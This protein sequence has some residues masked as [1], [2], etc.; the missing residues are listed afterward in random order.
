M[1]TINKTA[2]FERI[3]NLVYNGKGGVGK[4]TVAAH[5]HEWLR[6]HGLE[7]LLLDVDDNKSLTRLCSAAVPHALKGKVEVTE[8]GVKLSKDVVTKEGVESLLHRVLDAEIVL[9]DNPANVTAEFAQLF[10]AAQFREEFDSIGARLNFL[11]VLT[12]TDVVAADEARRLVGAIKRDAN[13]IVILNER[14][15]SDFSGYHG[16]PT[17]QVLQ[18]LTAPEIRFPAIPARIQQV[19]DANR[20][21]LPGYI[22]HYWELRKTD[23]KAAFKAT[24]PAQEAVTALRTAFQAFNSIAGALLPTA[25]AAKI[26]PVD[27]EKLKNF[28]I[29]RW[30]ERQ[31]QKN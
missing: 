21:T 3:L 31:G 20:M 12:A 4:T 15:G 28:C 27:A 2:E 29:T 10:A 30:Q 13:Y 6:Y 19:L 26:Q 16:S 25:I 9:A 14:L 17:H 7:H 1:S 24:L 5:I 11:L 22:G 23:P 18:S 8:D